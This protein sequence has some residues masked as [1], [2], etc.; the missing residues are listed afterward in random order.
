MT[1]QTIS[2]CSE[3][4]Q[5]YVNAVLTQTTISPELKCAQATGRAV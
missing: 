4:V 1:R 2:L 3:V 5:T